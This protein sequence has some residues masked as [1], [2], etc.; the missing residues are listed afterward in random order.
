M[1][2]GI[3]ELADNFL[4][5]GDLIILVLDGSLQDQCFHF[6][7]SFAFTDLTLQFFDSVF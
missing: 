7:F 1:G 2:F 5:L 4:E 6:C 3:I